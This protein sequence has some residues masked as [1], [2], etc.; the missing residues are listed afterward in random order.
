VQGIAEVHCTSGDKR[1]G[2]IV[3][4]NGYH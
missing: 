3:R 4:I 1:T 2:A